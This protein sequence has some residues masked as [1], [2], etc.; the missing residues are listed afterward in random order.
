MDEYGNDQELKVPIIVMSEHLTNKTF[1]IIN[2]QDG[3]KSNPDLVDDFYRL[4][5]RYELN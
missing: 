2:T 3:F 5:S 4:S 1:S